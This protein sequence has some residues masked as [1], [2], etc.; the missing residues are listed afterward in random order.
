MTLTL[1]N[2]LSAFFLAPRVYLG[3]MLFIAVAAGLKQYFHAPSGDGYTHYNNYVIFKQSF[4]HLVRGQDLYAFHPAEHH[5]NFLYS[6]TF[7][8]LMAPMATLPD[9]AGLLL[10]DLLN[11][12]VL[13]LA[14][15][16]LPG[17]DARQKGLVAWF[18]AP[19]MLGS[20]QSCQSNPMVA[21]LLLLAFYHLEREN[22]PAASFMVALAF[23]VKIFPLVAGLA[24]LLYRE[25]LRLVA[26]TAAWLA[27]LALVPLLFVSPAQLEFLYRS[28]ARLHTASVHAASFGLSVQGWLKTWFGLEPSRLAVLAVGGALAAAPLANVRAHAR[29]DFR[30]RTL[31]SLMMWMIVFNHLAESPT[32]VIAMCGVALWCFPE[33]RTPLR[34]VLAGVA[35]FFVSFT[36]SDL[37]PTAW[38]EQFVKPYVL[39]GVAVILAWLAATAEQLLAGRG[40]GPP[41]GPVAGRSGL[42]SDE[43][44]G[45]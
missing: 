7:A 24:F 35:F 43:T 23:Y 40:R 37:F 6:P 10:W 5:D 28:W 2:R 9:W 13:A 29:F 41:G 38:R 31:A 8:A 32:F 45:G 44:R 17:L 36:Y 19:E 3:A 1:R 20:I 25:R 26:W 18:V 4:F 27:V 34:S 14:L 33:P 12:S 11:A 22:A 42:P 16:R 15:W 30:L 39:K 21:G